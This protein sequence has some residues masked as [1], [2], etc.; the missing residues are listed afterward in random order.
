MTRIVCLALMLTSIMVCAALGQQ[1]KPSP[2]PG[3]I[4]PRLIR[5]GGGLRTV[6]NEA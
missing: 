2:A 6:G 5:F 3:V 4:V 1:Q